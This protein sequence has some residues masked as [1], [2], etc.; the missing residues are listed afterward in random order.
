MSQNVQEIPSA[1]SSCNE[2]AWNI[3]KRTPCWL[4]IRQVAHSLPLGMTFCRPKFRAKAQARMTCTRHRLKLPHR[5]KKLQRKLQQT[6]RTSSV[7]MFFFCFSSKICL[8]YLAHCQHNVAPTRQNR[9]GYKLPFS[10]ERK[11]LRGYDPLP[12]IT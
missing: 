7:V 3:S 11:H 8:A 2:P 6:L 1:A 12:C 10:Q 4:G 5:E 9:G